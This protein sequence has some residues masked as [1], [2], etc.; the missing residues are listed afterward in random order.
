MDQVAGSHMEV[1]RTVCVEGSV[2]NARTAWFA[3]K[4]GP[5]FIGTEVATGLAR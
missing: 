4:W 1:R 3:G 5:S 2:D